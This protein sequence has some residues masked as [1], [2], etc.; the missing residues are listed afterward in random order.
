MKSSYRVTH[1]QPKNRD[2]MLHDG[3]EV[4]VPVFDAKSMILDLLTNKITMDKSNIAEGY[5]VF[6]GNVD[7]RHTANKQ[8]GEIHTGDAWYPACDRFFT[9]KD[10]NNNNMPVGS[11]I[12]GDK[13]HTD[14]QGALSLTPIIFTLTMFNRTSRN[15]TNFWRL[16]GYIPNLGYGK[17]KADKTD[18]RDKIQDEHTCLSAVFESVREIHRKGG[19]LATVMG[20]EVTIKVW[21]HYFIGDTEG[22]NKWLGHYPG[23]KRQV[24]QPY[25]ILSVTFQN[26]QIQIQ[27]VYS[28]RLRRCMQ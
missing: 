2:V 17:N 16:L 3:F 11:I 25:V 27:H 6:T 18:T 14:L 12:F 20:R 21:I 23:N 24:S 9:P 15:N 22:N 4:T 26:C 7:D 5:N 28:L 1:L 19:F 10:D 13:S 8:Y